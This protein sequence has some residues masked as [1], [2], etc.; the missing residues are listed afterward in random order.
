[1]IVVRDDSQQTTANVN[2]VESDGTRKTVASATCYIRPGKGMNF[3]VDVLDDAA[4]KP[5]NID[6][7]KET[8]AD[9][10]AEEIEKAA[11]LDVPVMMPHIDG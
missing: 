2:V 1:M 4:I 7:V 11:A 8:I 6:A 9:Y 5:E 3:S 10:M